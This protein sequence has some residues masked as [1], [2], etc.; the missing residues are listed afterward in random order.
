MQWGV[1][2]PRQEPPGGPKVVG[3]DPDLG[4]RGVWPSPL[5]CTTKN[6]CLSTQEAL[7]GCHAHWPLSA[8]HWPLPA[9]AVAHMLSI[10]GNFLTGQPKAR[11]GTQQVLSKVWILT[12]L[13]LLLLAGIWAVRR[14]SGDYKELTSLQEGS[15][16]E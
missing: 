12:Q 8:N 11:K 6:L 15:L 1:T 5:L 7:L 10:E 14:G 16:M 3:R 13:H 9:L 4:G 2:V